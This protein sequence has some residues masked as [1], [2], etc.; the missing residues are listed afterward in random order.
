MQENKRPGQSPP[1]KISIVVPVYNDAEYLRTFPAGGRKGF[2]K[3]LVLQADRLFHRFVKPFY[4][5]FG[6]GSRRGAD[7]GLGGFADPDL[8]D[9]NAVQ[10]T[11]TGSSLH[12]NGP[13]E[14]L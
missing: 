4:L 10:Y 14:A 3:K 5:G 1:V 13:P 7:P 6:V 9:R 8:T 11:F 12:S 2:V